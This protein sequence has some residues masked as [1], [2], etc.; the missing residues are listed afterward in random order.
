[1]HRINCYILQKQKFLYCLLFSSPIFL[2]IKA[3]KFPRQSHNHHHTTCAHNY[4]FFGFR[5]AV[6]K[7]TSCFRV[8]LKTLHLLIRYKLL[9]HLNLLHIFTDIWHEISYQSE[10]HYNFPHIK[11]KMTAVLCNHTSKTQ[12]H[13]FCAK[14]PLQDIFEN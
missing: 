8:K 6:I 7:K 4:P 12:Q 13:T 1:V 11:Y 9:A 5:V 3:E 2:H 14:R 10:G